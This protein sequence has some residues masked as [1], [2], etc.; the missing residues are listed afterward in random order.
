MI[1]FRKV[2]LEDEA[3]KHTYS[4]GENQKPTPWYATVVTVTEVAWEIIYIQQEGAFRKHRINVLVILTRIPRF[5]VTQPHTSDRK[6][7]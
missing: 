5:K 2:V 7:Q 4:K 3:R 1:P 6:L